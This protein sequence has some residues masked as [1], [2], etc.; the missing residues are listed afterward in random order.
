MSQRE[1][2]HDHYCEWLRSEPALGIDLP[3][4]SCAVVSTPGFSLFMGSRPAVPGQFVGQ[5]TADIK[6]N[7]ASA[8]SSFNLAIDYLSVASS[9]SLPDAPRSTSGS[10]VGYIRENILSSKKHFQHGG[11]VL[12]SLGESRPDGYL[13]TMWQVNR[14]L[15]KLD[16]SPPNLMAVHDALE[17]AIL[18][19]SKFKYELLS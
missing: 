11:R 6:P 7:K 1:N 15:R 3:R 8:N 9:Y 16:A 14:A 17:G 13:R 4:N 19:A 2:H 18:H 12:E 10:Q 5:R